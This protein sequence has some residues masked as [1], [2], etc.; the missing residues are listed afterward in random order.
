MYESN[1]KEDAGEREDAFSP[2]NAA[3]LSL[4]VQMRIYDVLMALL[5]EQDETLANRLHEL[6]SAGRVLGSLPWLDMAANDSD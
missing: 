6:H 4:V 5:N 3:K 2:E 1:E